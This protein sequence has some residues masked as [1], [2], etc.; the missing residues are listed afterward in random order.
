V[1]EFL[2]HLGAPEQK[3]SQQNKYYSVPETTYLIKNNLNSRFD[4]PVVRF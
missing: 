4:L 1:S 2:F 3:Q